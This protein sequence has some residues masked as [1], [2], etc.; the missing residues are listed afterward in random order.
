MPVPKRPNGV[1]LLGFSLSWDYVDSNK[2]VVRRVL[3]R[4]EDKQVL[5]GQVHREDPEPCRL[6]AQQIRDLLTLEIPNVKHGGSLEASFKRMRAA[7]RDFVRAAGA[8][9]DNFARDPSHFWACLEAMRTSVG[10]EV[11]ALAAEFNVELEDAFVRSLPAQ[12]L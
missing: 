7:T 10:E 9:S 4:L 8:F 5:W 6:S 3:T 1:G 11:V 2:D 12:D